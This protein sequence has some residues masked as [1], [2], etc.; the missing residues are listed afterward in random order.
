MAEKLKGNHE[1]QPHHSHEQHHS[2]A[3]KTPEK[4]HH[5][6]K[7]KISQIRETAAEQALTS[8]QASADNEQASHTPRQ[9]FVNS[10]LKDLAYARTLKR[11]RQNFNRPTRAF[12]K[13]I[14]QP[15]VDA[16]SEGVAKTVGRPS[17]ILGGGLLALVGTTVYYYI[18]KHYGYDYNFF[19]FLALLASGFVAAWCIEFLL[20]A[21]RGSR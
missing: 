3:N 13:V 16:V 17:G 21:M 2:N 9:A 4:A 12:S 11:V 8:E 19:V 15:V 20:R 14:H 7:E 5:E 6:H 1:Q 10:E 18:T